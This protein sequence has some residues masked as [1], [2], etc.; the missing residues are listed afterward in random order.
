MWDACTNCGNPAH[1]KK[2]AG[3]GT[4]NKRVQ[5]VVVN[6]AT[7]IVEEDDYSEGETEY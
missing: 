5:Q 1:K 4:S 2:P 6:E 3:M 7:A